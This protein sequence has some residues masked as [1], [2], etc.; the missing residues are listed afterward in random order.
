MQRLFRVFILA[1]FVVCS[2]PLLAVSQGIQQTPYSAA[3]AVRRSWPSIAPDFTP[4]N[5]LGLP[6][7]SV[8]G[9]RGSDSISISSG[10]FQGILPNVP[11]LQLGY[12]YT[13]GPKLRA[14][15][16]S[17]DYLLPF[18]LGA[19]STIYGEAHG[20]FQ[21]LSIAQPGSPN[22]SVELCFGGGYRQDVRQSHHDRVTFLFRHDKTV[23][24]LVFIWK[25]RR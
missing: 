12:N 25:R 11:N 10:M 15:T 5:P 8:V 19:D 2:S 20:E 1:S 17:I 4:S 13:F 16:A 14:G 7:S 3:D 21:S 9:Q 24:R 22:N 18:K 23:R 6:G